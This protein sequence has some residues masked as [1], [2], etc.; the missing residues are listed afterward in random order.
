MSG[1]YEQQLA[2]A[3]EGTREERGLSDESAEEVALTLHLMNAHGLDFGGARE[4]AGPLKGST[5]IAWWL[6][7]DGGALTFYQVVLGD[8][9]KGIAQ[10]LG[11]L[12]TMVD[13][14]SS[15]CAI[16]DESL[17]EDRPLRALARALR[18]ATAPL[19]VV[20]ASLLTPAADDVV[21]RMAAFEQTQSRLARSRWPGAQSKGVTLTHGRVTLRRGKDYRPSFY[22][23]RGALTGPVAVEND[24]ELWAGLV[25]FDDLVALFDAR[26][27]SIFDKNV[28]YT[29]TGKDSQTRVAGPMRASLGRVA[30]GVLPPDY[31]TAYHVGVTLVATHC[32]RVGDSA[33]QLEN[34]YVINGCQSISTAHA[35]WDQRIRAK[36][37]D[38]L[39]RLSRIRVV[40]KVV[41][42]PT[43]EHSHEISNSNNC[44]D[45]MGFCR[46]LLLLIL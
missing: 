36:D 43:E 14:A 9:R 7:E 24:T 46:L 32:E 31:F 35:F 22:E 40:A 27:S 37:A 45:S 42:R 25:H 41:V 34:P 39:E 20:R 10:A 33:I 38:G 28:R 19:R 4:R 23:L 18:G 8:D 21:E 29:L 30:S 5:A 17:I 12:A 15:V 13:R 6:D 1:R 11:R 16:Q 26:G 44:Q 2:R 3:I